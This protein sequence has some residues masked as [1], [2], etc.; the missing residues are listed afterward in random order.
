MA[1]PL[2]A[3]LLEEFLNSLLRLFGI[4]SAP[5]EIQP[6]ELTQHEADYRRPGEVPEISRAS[7]RGPVREDER[8]R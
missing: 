4:R 2:T 6:P 5:P 1:T 8:T 3:V 7:E